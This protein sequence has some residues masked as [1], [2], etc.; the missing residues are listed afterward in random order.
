MD[1]YKNKK[2]KR[3]VARQNWKP[4]KLLTVL[5]G[6]WVGFYSAVKVAFAAVATVL[7]ILGI[8]AFVFVGVLADY[9]EGDILPQA[10]VQ[11]EG[12][13]LNQP[14]YIYYIDDAGNIQVL[15]KL[16]ADTESEW[17]EYHE[18]PQAMVYAAVAIE[19]HRFFEHQ[20][21]DW[22]TTMK[23]CVGMFVGS[24]DAGGSS[25]TQQL[26]KNLLLSK[27]PSADDVTVQ[28]KVLEWFRATEFEKKYDKTVVL[29][30]YL[31]Y[32]FLGN[33]CTG[34]KAAAE[35]YFGKELEDLT[36]AECACIISITNNPSI[37]NPISNKEVTYKG[38]TRTCAE[39][40]K[41]RREN[42]LWVMRNYGYL[43][44]E[45]YQAALEDSATLEF[46]SG[47]AFEDRYSDCPE[48]GY[49]AH[50]DQ[51]VKMEDIFY[52]PDC[53]AATTIGEDVSQEVYSW[54]VDTVINDLAADMADKAG[55]DS[56]NADVMKL[57]RNLIAQGGY[58][59]YSTLDLNVQN[60][61]DKIY[62][63]LDEIPTTSS[64][65]QLQSGIC[66][67]DNKTGDI[68]AISGGVGE[69]SVYYAYN[70]ATVDRLQPGSSIKPLTVYAPAFEM[71][72]IN[73]ASVMTDMPL[74]YLGDEEDDE[75]ELNPYPKNDNRVYQYR[76]N[77]LAAI[78]SSVN[79]MSVQTLATMGVQTSFDFAK[80]KFRLDGLKEQ[81]IDSNGNVFSDIDIAP[82]GMGAPS[83]GVSVRDMSAAFA[84]FA[85]NGVWREPRTYTH[86]YNTDGE[87]VLYNE[88]ESEQILS[89]RTVNYINY[90]LT[91]AV[92]NGTGTA[93]QI[94]GQYVA[95][96]TGTTA[97]NKD[98]W[99]CGF[100]KYYSA[101][102]WCGYDQ[103]EVMQLTGN[104]QNPAARLFQKVLAP[105]HEGKTS[106]KLYND[107]NWVNVNICLD[108]GLL[109]TSACSQD[110]RGNRV[111]KALVDP[112]DP[113][114]PT[115]SC[116]KHVAV[117]YCETCK[118]P[119]NEYCLKLAEVG[120]TVLS[121]VYLVKL[122][123]EEV[124]SIRLATM[125]G[126]QSMYKSDSYIY[127]VDELGRDL[128]FYGMNGDKNQGVEYP[129]IVGTAH[130]QQDWED[131]L[132]SQLATTPPTENTKPSNQIPGIFWP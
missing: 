19:D 77:I 125:H 34:V 106:V 46:K 120:E 76:R 66:V 23:A 58:H 129:Y 32:I 35:K 24:A 74:R 56:T 95:G 21:V 12:F 51:F 33:R 1:D 87:L 70:R 73:P 107:S 90:C 36:P 43:T 27:D 82:L 14:S 52:C 79:A 69:K 13:E 67:I 5:H 103:P 84:T 65:Q 30:W 100:T 86:V 72:I 116:N 3:L 8:C 121:D 50:N 22:F 48:C 130:T 101:G 89:E 111:V 39:W 126:L 131:Y 20:G 60:S 110:C 108:S 61:V 54:F 80:Y 83:V 62:T 42:T 81:Y 29:E 99:F 49:H 44:E 17:A 15:Q 47:I 6:L 75:W 118:A 122:T 119:A 112:N 96:K 64:M 94:S 88:Q 132:L 85:N 78:T 41:V 104:K 4:G 53:G 91:N 105:L 63:N 92:N 37:F 16:Y 128:P 2:E 98:R 68:V 7:I 55:Q 115:A 28:R 123:F 9:L 113:S 93:A 97:S 38:E 114:I 26:I 11:L 25:I 117:K 102:V 109:A 124:N 31:N 57:Y 40:N 71:G 59:I 10:G 45:E 18:I 127:L